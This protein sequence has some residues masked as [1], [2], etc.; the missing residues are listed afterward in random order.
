MYNFASGYFFARWRPAVILFLG[1]SGYDFVSV[2]PAVIL[3]FGL[4]APGC[5][6][7]SRPWQ[8][9]ILRGVNLS[10]GSNFVPAINWAAWYYGLP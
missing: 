3:S 4:V 8:N 1:P 6:F 10:S 7:V 5:N 2:P 9:R